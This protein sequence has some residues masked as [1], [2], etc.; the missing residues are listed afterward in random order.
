MAGGMAFLVGTALRAVRSAAGSENPP[1]LWLGGRRRAAEGR[2]VASPRPPSANG[3]DV[4]ASL[5]ARRSREGTR[6]QEGTR[7]HG[8]KG[9]RGM[10]P[11]PDQR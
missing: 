5:P 11:E 8:D 9:A 6:S 3:C 10:A 4:I 2:G 7:W 1:Y